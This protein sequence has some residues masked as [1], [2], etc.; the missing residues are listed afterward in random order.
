[1][2]ASSSRTPSR[3]IGTPIPDRTDGG[4][5]MNVLVIGAGP[6][7]LAAAQAACERGASVTVIDS[8]GQL[9]GQYWRHLP[10]ERP[11]AAERVLH[12]GW[13]TFSSLCGVA[14][15]ATVRLSAQV[16][17]IESGPSGVVVHAAVGDA[18]GDHRDM[19]ALHP[20][21]LVLATGAHDR[22]LPVPGWT[23]PGVYS[24]GAA[25]AMAKGERIALG[26]RV[27]VSGAGPFLLPVTRS[28]GQAGAHV[29]GVY[30]AGRVPALVRGWG[31]RAWELA[32]ASHKL[33]EFAGYI[34]HHVRHRVPYHLGSQVVA[35]HGTD[36]VEAAT[37]ARLDEQWRPVRG[38]E[39]TVACDT[40][41]LGHGFT[42]RLE[43][44][45]AAGCAL[46]ADR[47]VQV[48]DAQETSVGGVYAAGEITTLGGVDFALATGRIA[49]WTAAGGSAS[50]PDIAR[51]VR[52]RRR[53]AAFAARIEAAHGI[54]PGWV[55]WLTDDTVICRC[56]D[57]RYDRFRQTLAGT[58]EPGM[59]STKLTTRAGLGLCQGRVCGR[60]VE[61]L[62][63]NHRTGDRPPGDAIVDRRPI[64]A[65]VTLG[66]LARADQPASTIL[67]P[68]A[69]GIVQAAGEGRATTPAPGT[70]ADQGTSMTTTTPGTGISP[71]SAS[72]SGASTSSAPG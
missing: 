33:T 62:L 24:A 13:D 14:D 68:P 47:Y 38:S 60:T 57:V 23:L 49:G 18:D 67:P 30:E 26:R 61:A 15:Q 71:G 19:V 32:G 44:P 39:R 54:R 63:A 11:A 40:V 12:H 59:R 31:R 53:F 66:E 16:W 58:G 48:D 8:S 43:L 50:D 55:E 34:G 21:A 36:R 7:G 52:D 41:C 72:G 42:P 28:L 5:R 2:T 65:P 20:D 10:T 69:T 46:T 27:V 29:L 70:V 22:T 1:M 25:Q 37:V 4:E 35:I 45:I 6:A 3:P 51:A 9:G 56:E 17:A 64:A